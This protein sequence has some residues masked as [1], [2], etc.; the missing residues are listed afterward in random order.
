M[1]T[2]KLHEEF[3]ARCRGE[4]GGHQDIKD[5]L[6]A[7][8][9]YAFGRKVVAEFGTRTGNSTVAL[10]TGLANSGGG[11]LH[12]YDLDFSQFP[13]ELENEMTASGVAVIKHQGDTANAVFTEHPDFVFID[14]LH[15]YAHVTAELKAIE[16]SGSSP[17]LIAFHDVELNGW[18]GEGGQPGILPAI[19]E[20]MERHAYFVEYYSRECNGLLVIERAY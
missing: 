19:L 4:R 10:A 15:T 8:A 12:L 11:R 16:K 2:Q 3:N 17:G 1:I 14:T 6:A 13:A 5:H 18:H 9:S 20:F 7:L